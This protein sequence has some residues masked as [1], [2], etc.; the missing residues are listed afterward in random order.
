MACRFFNCSL[1]R[2]CGFIL[3]AFL[4]VASPTM[5]SAEDSQIKAMRDQLV[6]AMKH[7]ELGEWNI[8]VTVFKRS[9]RW[10]TSGLNVSND[11]PTTLIASRTFEQQFAS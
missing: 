7:F 9:D 8:Q 11:T 5:A 4:I 6:G 2:A 1:R 10:R 3:V